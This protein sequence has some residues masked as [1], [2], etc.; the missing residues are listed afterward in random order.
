LVSLESPTLRELA[1]F[2]RG[3]VLSVLVTAAARAQES[4]EVPDCEQDASLSRAAGELLLRGK[5]PDSA[6][7]TR[8]VRAAGS[9]AVFVRG[10]YWH[11]AEA[12]AES[13]LSE[14]KR[15]A[16]APAV[17][18]Y[19]Q[20]ASERL[21]L[22]AAKAGW[23]DALSG[24]SKRVRGRLADSFGDPVLVL[25]DRDGALRRLPVAQEQLIRGVAIPAELRRPVRVQLVASGPAGPRPVAE[26]TLPAAGG[27]PD[28]EAALRRE[29]AQPDQS[30]AAG[31]GGPASIAERLASLRRAHQLPLLR[32]NALLERVAAAHATQ[33]CA[34]GVVAHEPA[35][36]ADPKVRLHLAGV[37]AR[38]VGET[39]ARSET[40]RSAFEAFEHSPSHRLTML[41]RS[42]T[43]VGIG[44]AV[45]PTDRHCLVILLASWPRYVG[46]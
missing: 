43:D 35:T 34:S 23:L 5:L 14:F 15:S 8:M 22:V 12:G 37:D 40:A 18:G 38:R 24:K 39:V 6:A 26:R 9:D 3:A 13:W 27:A 21:L 11:P 2:L 4:A 7:V 16:D 33:V 1:S 44:Q 36:G 31:A 19:A 45:D 28:E 20:G 25:S 29:A 32:A 42:F 46:R 41:E 10:Y 17:C 30:V